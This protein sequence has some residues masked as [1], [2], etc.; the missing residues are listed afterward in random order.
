MIVSI[1]SGINFS[2][3]TA[4]IQLLR[5]CTACGRTDS[6]SC[7]ITPTSCPLLPCTTESSLQ[8]NSYP[9]NLSNF[10]NGDS[11]GVILS[12]H[13]LSDVENATTSFDASILPA[14]ALPVRAPTA[15]EP[16]I[17]TLLPFTTIPS[18]LNVPI[19]TVSSENTSKIGI[20]EISFTE[21]KEPDNSS[22]NV[23]SVPC[24][25]SM[26][27]TVEPDLYICNEPVICKS[28]VVDWTEPVAANIPPPADIPVS[29]EPSI[30]GKAEGNL[31]SGIVPD[32]KFEAF[33]FVID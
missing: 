16:V 24:E 27:N 3:R 10:C 6:T 29:A 23:K 9:P 11:I 28:F 26:L 14:V 19:L 7:A 22:V 30:A 5:V 20:P 33:K 2:Y 25:P 8:S 31:A 18:A 12:F 17:T 4:F 1:R 21:N 13:L 15:N 32:D